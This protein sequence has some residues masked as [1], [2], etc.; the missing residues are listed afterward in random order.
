MNELVAAG[1]IERRIYR[2]RGRQVMLDRDLAEL[3]GVPTK[4]LNKAVKRH[5]KRF[6]KDFM[7]Q[8]SSDELTNWRFQFGTSNFGLKM[9]LRYRP[10][11]FT[12]LGVSMLSS[13]LNN[14]RAIE[15]NIAIMRVFDRLRE[16]IAEDRGLAALV[17]EH[18]HRLDK[19][20]H[21]VDGHDQD[22]AALIETVPSLPEPAP[23]PKSVIGFTPPP[24]DKQKDSAS[25]SSRM[26]Q[27]LRRRLRKSEIAHNWPAGRSPRSPQ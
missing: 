22:I 21:R 18:E 2:I 14:D 26:R 5:P 19:C 3:Y 13:V 9:G 17:T 25:P 1:F 11:A 27:N 6:P 8:L 7:I 10:Y 4:I 23:E 15:V 24:K 20:E 12:S 16:L